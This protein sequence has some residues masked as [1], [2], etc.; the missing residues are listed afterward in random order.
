MNKKQKAAILDKCITL[1]RGNECTPMQLGM[2]L[3][4]DDVA[5]NVDA[6]VVKYLK[7]ERR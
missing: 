5:R 3:Q 6:L 2:A 7:D 1:M 4:S